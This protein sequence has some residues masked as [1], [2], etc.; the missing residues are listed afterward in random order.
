MVE[1]RQVE[2][3]LW[4]ICVVAAVGLLLHEMVFLSMHFENWAEHWLGADRSARLAAEHPDAWS[5]ARFAWWSL[6]TATVWILV[7]ALVARRWL[8]KGLADYGV[9]RMEP[10]GWRPYLIL[11]AVGVPAL[12][13]ATAI[14]PG[15]PDTY[16]LYRPDPDQWRLSN[17]IVYE[18]LYGVQFVAVEF[19]FRGVLVIG[20]SRMIG[21]R[22]VF[23][24]MIPYAMI[25]VYK[26]IPEAFAAIV[27]G[28][29]LG[30]LALRSKS[31]WGGVLLH[32]AVAWSTDLVAIVRRG[33]PEW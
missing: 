19:F 9:Q 2:R 1:D 5:L 4:L 26:P 3:E 16:P 24:A 17:I 25:H 11:A 22:S 14:L 21:Y 8:G 23:V 27:A 30:T 7:P 13:L 10:G 28:L 31:I 6:G 32:V 20:L 33:W 18:L 29:I 15:F 12:T